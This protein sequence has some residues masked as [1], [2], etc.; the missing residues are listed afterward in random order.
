MKRFSILLTLIVL[1]MLG[2]AVAQQAAYKFAV[3]KP[4][5]YLLEMKQKSM[6]EYQGETHSNDVD[7]TASIVLTVSKTNPDG[8]MEGS[9]LFENVLIMIESSENTQTIG[10]ALKGKTI[11]VKLHGDGHVLDIDTTVKIDDEASESF[12]PQLLMF[13]PR[14]DATKL[15]VGSEWERNTI[16]TLTSGNDPII[17]KTER[18]YK[19]V[20]TK[21]HKGTECLEITYETSSSTKGTASAGGNDIYING[22]NTD[23]GTILFDVKSGVLVLRQGEGSGEMNRTL[24]SQSVKVQINNTSNDKCEL[25][26]E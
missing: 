8:S 7:G 1:C 16:D 23:K 10:A 13:L 6:A 14:M 4:Y 2:T 11:G 25:V 21:T 3:G 19:A 17:R 9:V 15:T 18:K 26:T 22:D 5:K 20:G 12:V 24:P